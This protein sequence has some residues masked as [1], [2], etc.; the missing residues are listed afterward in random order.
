MRDRQLHA[1]LRTFAE[2]ASWTLTADTAE[3]A[4]V[5]FELIEE[6][7]GRDRPT[8]YC[9]RADTE[10]FIADRARDLHKLET[11]Q[12]TVRMLAGKAGLD[13]YLRSR[14]HTRVPVSDR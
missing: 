6:G 9:Y 4:E 3:G 10:A 5:P 7:G 12:P 1:A 2:E 11:W 8:L 13:A 14:G